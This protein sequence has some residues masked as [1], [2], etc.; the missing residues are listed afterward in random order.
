[1]GCFCLVIGEMLPSTPSAVEMQMPWKHDDDYDSG[2]FPV[3]Q[4]E[5]PLWVENKEYTNYYSPTNT[6]LGM[7][8]WLLLA[9]TRRTSSL[10]FQYV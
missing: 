7:D 10:G 9:V 4:S 1:M 5:F 2:M 8:I 6:F 3:K